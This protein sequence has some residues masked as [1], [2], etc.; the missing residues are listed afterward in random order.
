M[1]PNLKSIIKETREEEIAQDIEK[2]K[3]LKN[4]I[5]HSVAESND[6]TKEEYQKVD[7]EYIITLLSD[8]RVRATVKYVGRIGAKVIK[9]SNHHQSGI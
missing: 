7:S 6:A 2:R 9:T 5:V 1:I 8:I 4:I 3:R